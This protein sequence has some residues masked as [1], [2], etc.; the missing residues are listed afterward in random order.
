MNHRWYGTNQLD[1]PRLHPP[2]ALLCATR[3]PTS[4]LAA[5][6]LTGPYLANKLYATTVA[7]TNLA[8]R[9][10]DVGVLVQVRP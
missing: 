5:R 1:L 6:A 9:H 10:Y 4:E 7:V 3:E 2:L 8:A